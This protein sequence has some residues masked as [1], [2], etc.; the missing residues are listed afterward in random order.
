MSKKIGQEIANN[1]LK[2]IMSGDKSRIREIFR[3][4]EY[5]FPVQNGVEYQVQTLAYSHREEKDLIQIEIIVDDGRRWERIA[6]ATVKRSELKADDDI[7]DGIE[8]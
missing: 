3:N 7:V 8:K 2:E 6:R 1:K 5:E 4:P